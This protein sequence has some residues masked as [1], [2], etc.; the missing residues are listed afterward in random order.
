MLTKIA[1]L[2]IAIS[3]ILASHT[4]ADSA[5]D[6]QNT[7]LVIYTI[8]TQYLLNSRTMQNHKALY[9]ESLNAQPIK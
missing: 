8:V 3:V 5:P 7:K 6:L 1:I 9:Q 4:S 2:S